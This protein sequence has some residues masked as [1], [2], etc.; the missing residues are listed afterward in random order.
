MK[1]YLS[2]ADVARKHDISTSRVAQLCAAGL[3]PGAQKFGGSWLIPSSW[4]FIP[5][6]P[7]PKSKD[8]AKKRRKPA[9]R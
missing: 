8:T 7:G 2:T 4:K 1:G 9:G 5:G 6:K 3:V